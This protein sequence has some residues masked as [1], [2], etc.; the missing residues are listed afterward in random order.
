MVIQPSNGKSFWW[1]LGKADPVNKS[2]SSKVA[3]GTGG[4]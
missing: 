4:G 3:Q 2:H 1:N